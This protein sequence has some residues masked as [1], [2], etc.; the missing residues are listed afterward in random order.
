VGER[1]RE[2]KGAHG[3]EVRCARLGSDIAVQTAVTRF[4][5]SVACPEVPRLA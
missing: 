4:I 2:V 5:G 3:S 1:E